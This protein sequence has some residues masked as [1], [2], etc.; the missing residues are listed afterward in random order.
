[1]LAGERERLLQ[2][3]APGRFALAGAGVDQIERGARKNRRRG[4]HRRQSFRDV[5]AA[6]ERLEVV[7]VERLHADRQAVD[8]GGAIA[9]K[10]ARFDAG[11]IGLQR[12]L[13]VGRERPGGGDG[14]D[15]AL[16]GLRP[17]QRRRAAAKEDR[18]RHTARG[19]RGAM[20]DLGFEGGDKAVFVD[21]LGP[22]MRVEIAIGA[23]GQTERPMDID[24]EAG[25]G[26]APAR[27]G[28]KVAVCDIAAL[29]QLAV[30]GARLFAGAAP[31]YSFSPRAG[32][33]L[34]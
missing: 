29:C 2:L 31:H 22:H 6:A 11:R 33:R 1:M 28:A 30:R 4:L 9:A 23:F 10:A 5:V 7:I 14:V 13:G 20:G 17:H 18:A 19:L 3:G 8:A 24:G 25:V 26:R 16:H 34:G 15:Q 21:R 12:D 27:R 32:R